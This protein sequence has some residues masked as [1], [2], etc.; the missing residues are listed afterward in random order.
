MTL[1]ELMKLETKLMEFLSVS[2]EEMREGKITP[3]EYFTRHYQVANELKKLSAP[4]S[5]KVGV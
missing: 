1:N 2:Q 4:H 3:N 5:L